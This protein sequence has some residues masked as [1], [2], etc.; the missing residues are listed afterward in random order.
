MNRIFA[1]RKKRVAHFKKGLTD[2]QRH[3]LNLNLINIVED[4]VDFYLEK[5]LFLTISFSIF[6][7]KNHGYPIRWV[8]L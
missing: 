5:L 1:F 4:I 8:P 7:Y 6:S 2:S 3:P